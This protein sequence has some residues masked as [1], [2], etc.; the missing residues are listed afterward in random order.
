MTPVG[1]MISVTTSALNRQVVP[2]VLKIAGSGEM[3]FG[4]TIENINNHL[5]V[6]RE[7]KKSTQEFTAQLQAVPGIS[8]VV[9]AAISQP[10]TDIELS[11]VRELFA[12]LDWDANDVTDDQ[13]S[14]F[15][16]D[17]LRGQYTYYIDLGHK[18]NSGGTISMRIKRLEEHPE[19]SPDWLMATGGTK[20][21]RQDEEPSFDDIET[22]ELMIEMEEKE[23]PE[24][25]PPPPNNLDQMT[26]IQITDWLRK[27][28]RRILSDEDI[29][30]KRISEGIFITIMIDGEEE[31]MIYKRTR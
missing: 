27:H 24:P 13:L 14:L 26:D 25:P 21:K 30:V 1:Y 7:N 19:F 2:A 29:D 11:E 28:D 3:F 5:F 10:V 22:G 12:G 23:E 16:D 6:V 9:V 31:T 20:E 17:K 4:S 8:K 15:I 18:K